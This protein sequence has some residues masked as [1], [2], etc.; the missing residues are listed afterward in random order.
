MTLVAQGLTVDGR[1]RPRLSGVD[2]SLS[3]G[4][5]VA[6][7][8]PN[9]AGKTTL[10]R[11]LLGLT[12]FQG[13]VRLAEGS[14]GSLSP[15]ERAAHLAWLP[16]RQPL[17]EGLTAEEVVAAARFRFD[18]SLLASRAAAQSALERAGAGSLSSH[19][20]ETL[21]GGELQRVRL[22]TLMAQEAGLWLLDEPGNHLDPALQL[23][24]YESLV[25]EVQ[26]GRG[27]VLVTHDLLRLP[28]LAQSGMRVT[29]LVLLDGEVVVHGSLDDPSL[30][31]A[32]G[33]VFGLTLHALEV[34][35]HRRFVIG[36]RR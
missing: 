33:R 27:V 7:L 32:L 30:P 31:D 26:G 4:E 36:G 19:R 1:Q 28:F 11:A 20:V 25:A 24:L 21:S 14:V 16:Q 15:L 8:G 2:L 29:V 5:L 17:E 22:A 12:R 10:L 35:G 9:G 13:T 34:E 23:S 18:E 6:G 3:P